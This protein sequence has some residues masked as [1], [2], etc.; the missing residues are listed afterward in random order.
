MKRRA[1]GSVWMTAALVAAMNAS[2]A[3]RSF[4]P[5][6][7]KVNTDRWRCRLCPFELASVKEATW[8]LGAVHVAEASARFGRDSGLDEAGARADLGLGYRR[9]DDKGRMAEIAARRLGLDSRT[10]AIGVRDSRSRAHL[11]RREIPRNISADG[12]TPFAGTSTLTLPGDWLGAFDTARMTGLGDGTRF[13]HGTERRRTSARVRVDPLPDW[14][15]QA[16]Y[17]RETKSGAEQTFADFL[18]QSTG[19][20]KPVSFLTEELAT[21]AGIE[22]TAFTLAAELRNSRFRNR[23][24][25]L[26]W[27]SP[28][29]GPAVPRGRKALAPDNEARS[30]SLI[31]RIALGRRA[32]AHATLTWG[33]SRQDDVF[34]PYTTNTRLGT[35]PL[36]AYS[37]DGRVGSFAGT[38]R[39]VAR[40]TDRLRVTVLHR[41]RERDNQT[42]ALTFRP[43]R[44]D[45]YIPGAPGAVANR[46]HDVDRSTTELGVTYRVAPRVGLGLYTDSN[47]I[48]RAPAEVAE[49]EERR[50]RIEL[51]VNGWRGIRAKL[52]VAEADRVGSE[53]R[54]I[55]GNN[56]LTR[57]Y[58]QAAREQRIWRARVGYEFAAIGAFVEFL[59][60]CRRNAYPES[61]LGLQRDAN[62]TRG[63]DVAYTPRR[64]VAIAAFYYAQETNAATAGQVGLTGSDWRYSTGDVVDTA[65]ISLDVGALFDGRLELSVDYVR[66][67]GTG[68]Y[69]T[70][71]AGESQPFPDLVSNHASVDIHARYQW[72]EK[73]AF[74]FQMRNER[75]R[76]EDWA[77]VEALDAI[78]NV[79]P[80]GNAS[81]RY[82]NRSIGVSYEASF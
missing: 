64:D 80:F 38:F 13:I 68:A 60:E 54:H 59:A 61:A 12:V 76:S 57:R 77:L 7:A 41:Q 74:V 22:R 33:E 1:R 17:S 42:A 32:A 51:G 26:D 71:L 78:R 43:V 56:P 25:A 11:D 49:N 79:V 73:R 36:P 62:C 15:L 27:Q 30:L 31:S 58:H 63:G 44:G 37:L 20:P 10:V 29:R 46:A 23:H 19:L 55:T 18:Y 9:R 67:L 53:Y 4:E 39:L 6:Y 70:E 50:H 34:E 69:A 81:P 72:R 24:G 47:R 75:Y 14:W 2:A 45:L 35:D 8:T 16:G 52:S 21:S 65:G 28:W 48:R 5:N 66:S 3:D 40:P 82:A